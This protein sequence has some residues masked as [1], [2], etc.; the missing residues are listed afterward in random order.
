MWDIHSCE[1][2]LIPD[3]W[4]FPKTRILFTDAWQE[5]FKQNLPKTYMCLM[6]HLVGALFLLMKLMKMRGG[7]VCLLIKVSGI[8]LTSLCFGDQA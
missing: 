2:I 3:Y 7:I 6:T 5:S 8:F 1:R 4:K